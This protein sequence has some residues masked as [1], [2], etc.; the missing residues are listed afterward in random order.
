MQSKISKKIIITILLTVAI[1]LIGN[2]S[3]A[4]I[5]IVS[6]G[7]WVDINVSDAFDMCLDMANEGSTL[8]NQTGL[9]P[10]MATSL[11]WGAAAYLGQ[12]RY[13]ANNSSMSSNTTGNQSGIMNMNYNTTTAT[14]YKGRTVST[15]ENSN[16]VLYRHSL[17]SAI[18]SPTLSKYV[19]LIDVP[20]NN[21][22]AENTRGRAMAETINWYS[23]SWAIGGGYAD[24]P[25]VIRE[26]SAFG[27][28]F[29][30]YY[31]GGASGAA[32]SNVTFRPIIWN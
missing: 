24:H 3:Y 32:A 19:D 2:K 11:D 13:G 18:A 4:A 10:H 8:G 25:I 15:A 31:A 23:A 29:F 1:F 5:Q 21:V 14:M 30:V 26:G 20:Y 22:T 16:T 12:S 6:G 9:Q 7:K 28:A 27:V 17:E